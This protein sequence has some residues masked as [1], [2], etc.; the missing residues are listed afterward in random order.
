[1]PGSPAWLVFQWRDLPEFQGV[2]ASEE[3]AIAACRTE[4]HCVCP[5]TMDEELP[6]GKGEWPGSWY[7]HLEARP[8]NVTVQPPAGDTPETSTPR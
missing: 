6:Q 2:F 4:N 3:K 8:E 5:A 1:M 7:P